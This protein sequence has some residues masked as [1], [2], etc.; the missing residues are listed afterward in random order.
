[1]LFMIQKW[2]VYRNYARVRNFWFSI[3]LNVNILHSL[4][5]KDSSFPRKKIGF[6]HWAF[7]GHPSYIHIIHCWHYHCHCSKCSANFLSRKCYFLLCS[8][9]SSNLH[10]MLHAD[11]IFWS[12]CAHNSSLAFRCSQ[13]LTWGLKRHLSALWPS[14]WRN[15]R[16]LTSRFHLDDFA[17]D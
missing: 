5:N 16:D 15:D 1:M 14:G 11:S 6:L 7:S 3:I 12:V 13:D 4:R 8:L 17:L 2:H 10:L 9:P